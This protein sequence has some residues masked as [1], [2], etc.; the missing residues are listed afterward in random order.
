M[1]NRKL[2][3]HSV[4]EKESFQIELSFQ[5]EHIREKFL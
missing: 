4:F 2:Y 5:S 1:K 3:M